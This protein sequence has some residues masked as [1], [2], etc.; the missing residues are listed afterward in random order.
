MLFDEC[1]EFA[2][3]FVLGLQFAR[4]AVES[5]SQFLTFEFETVLGVLSAFRFGQLASEVCKLSFQ[6]AFL[7]V[8]LL[9]LHEQFVALLVDLDWLV[10]D[11]LGQLLLGE[12][13]V[14]VLTQFLVL[15][16]EAVDFL[17]LALLVLLQLSDEAFE[18]VGALLV[19][20]LE[21]VDEARGVGAG[22]GAADLLAQLLEFRFLLLLEHLLLL[23][24]E[25]D[26]VA[27]S[28]CGA[29]ARAAPAQPQF[30]QLLLQCALLSVQFL[31]FHE[32]F[33]AL[34]VN[35]D[36]LVFDQFGH[37]FLAERLVKILTQF[38]VLRGD[39]VDFLVFAL[40]VLL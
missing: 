13:L 23:L 30:V 33:V 27:Q 31:H 32:Q 3:F 20:S 22:G 12:R 6:L 34:L 5:R 17:V 9:I 36:M 35:L 40:L 14:E 37:F 16:G 2:D 39:A 1:V 11:Q 4:E 8:Q 10:F 29:L 38:L 19:R 26:G 18:L 25:C 21:L 24:H 7:A 15:L 28:F